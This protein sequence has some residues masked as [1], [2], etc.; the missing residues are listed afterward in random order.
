MCGLAVRMIIIVRKL[1]NQ[2]KSIIISVQKS[3]PKRTEG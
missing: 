3:I 2:S 1:T